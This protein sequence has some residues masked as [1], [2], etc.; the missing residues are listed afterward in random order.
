MNVLLCA[1]NRF[2]CR[3][4]LLFS[5]GFFVFLLIF[6]SPLLNLRGIGC[7]VLGVLSISVA[8]SHIA[9]WSL[10]REIKHLFDIHATV[11]NWLEIA[12]CWADA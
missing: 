9:V 5:V 2:V 3:T 10:H 8:F 4:D 6:L 7:I 12:V 11:I 1:L